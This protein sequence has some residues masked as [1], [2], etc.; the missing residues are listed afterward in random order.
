MLQTG[1]LLGWWVEGSRMDTGC[2]LGM[3]SKRALE[4]ETGKEC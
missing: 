1:D 4:N 2:F 3:W